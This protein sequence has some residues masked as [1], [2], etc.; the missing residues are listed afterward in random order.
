MD[1]WQKWVEDHA[2]KIALDSAADY[3]D[4]AL[5]AASA[6][7]LAMNDQEYLKATALMIEDVRVR[8]EMNDP[9][10]IIAEMLD[11]IQRPAET[12]ATHLQQFIATPTDEVIPTIYDGAQLLLSSA[13]RLPPPPW[14]QDP[15]K[16]RIAMASFRGSLTQERHRT[17]REFTTLIK[18]AEE[19]MEVLTSRHADLTSRVSEAT[20]GLNSLE[21]SAKETG[22]EFEKKTEEYEERVRSAVA[23]LD[24]SRAAI[25]AAYEREAKTRN[26]QFVT[27]EERRDSNFKTQSDRRISEMDR[28]I[29]HAKTVLGTSAATATF[30][31]ADAEAK[32]QAKAMNIWRITGMAILLI[33]AVVGVVLFVYDPPRDSTIV[34]AGVFLLSRLGVTG[35][36]GLTGYYAMRE[37]RHHR[38]R[39][40][41][42][43]QL[44]IDIASFRPF[45]AE[46]PQDEINEEVRQAAQR[47]FFRRTANDADKVED[48]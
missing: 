36:L 27:S 29:D 40:K 25:S 31:A 23:E 5:Q 45:L 44:A 37:A 47:T 9:R 13:Y 22:A 42:V 20:R 14:Q 41:E 11:P 21:Q 7:N 43:R 17:S 6:S 35:V 26:E 19:D 24:Q 38:E 34:G 30:A 18:K 33:A 2:V 16:I 46:L 48:E 15:S 8:L 4:K 12:L 28:L 39:E 1:F 3:A 32:K 10:L